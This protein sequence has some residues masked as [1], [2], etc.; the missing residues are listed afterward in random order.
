[1]DER[2]YVLPRLRGTSG[3]IEKA[4]QA[5]RRKLQAVS[6]ELFALEARASDRNA[7]DADVR[8]ARAARNWLREQS[9]A[10]FWLRLKGD[11][12]KHALEV[13]EAQERERQQQQPSLFA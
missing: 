13:L 12:L 1:M 4:R 2:S 6:E 3:Q 7:L 8:A 11:A 5:R 9:D 10:R